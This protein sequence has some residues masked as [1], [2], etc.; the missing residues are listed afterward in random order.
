MMDGRV[1]VLEIL[2]LNQVLPH[3]NFGKL[4]MYRVKHYYYY[5][6]IHR[7]HPA[8]EKSPSRAPPPHN[9]PS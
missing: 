1:Y 4:D 6:T 3:A 8:I 9:H 5:V 2:L 7:N